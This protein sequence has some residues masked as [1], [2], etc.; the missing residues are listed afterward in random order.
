MKLPMVK[1]GW[2]SVVRIALA[3]AAAVPFGLALVAHAVGP[4]PQRPQPAAPDR[5]AL[6]F[7]Q[8]MVNFGPIEP[9]GTVAARFGFTNHSG[10]PVEIR[11]LKPS[12]GCLRPYLRKHTFQP[13]ESGEFYVRVQTANEEPGPHEYYVDM[14]YADPQPRDVRL[15][16]KVVLPEQQ[17]TVRPKALIFYQLSGRPTTRE[18]MVTDAR[19]KS[20][21][22][23]TGVETSSKLVS[24]VIG[25]VERGASGI[26][27]IPVA[28]T[29][30][31]RVPPGRHRVLVT[32][33]TN[34]SDYPQLRVPLRI[35]GPKEDRLSFGGT[36]GGGDSGHVR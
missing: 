1:L 15:T 31:G 14:L 32:L 11:E 19:G 34:D 10:H 30:E 25:P 2:R 7:D 6:A 33:Q 24:A 12:C 26:R 5:P 13:D 28:V 3:A 20:G 22:R 16:F 27:R 35:Y 36:D 4:V 8:Y 9:V 18:L 29:V 23:L 17:V 21:L